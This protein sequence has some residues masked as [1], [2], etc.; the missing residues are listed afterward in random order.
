MERLAERL[1]IRK[2]PSKYGGRFAEASTPAGPVGLLIP[3]TFMNLAGDAVSPAAGAL[4]AARAQVLVVHDELDLPFGIVRGK[5]GGGHGGHNGLR[6]V[7]ARL[8]GDDYLRIRLGIGRPP[9]AFRGDQADWVLMGFNEPA[10]RV[11]AMVD[12]GVAMAEMVVAEG[13][14]AAIA[15]FHA[16]APGTRARARRE[17]KA[18]ERATAQEGDGGTVAEPGSEH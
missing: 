2:L 18:A 3:E 17:R 15:R 10:D 13:M 12:A 16:A 7:S 4:H 14:D 9:A 5:V 1:G 11:A 8:G 6:S